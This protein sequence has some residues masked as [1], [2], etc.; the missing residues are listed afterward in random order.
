MG[1]PSLPRAKLLLFRMTGTTPSEG[2]ALRSSDIQAPLRLLGL[3]HHGS[4]N[5]WS[6]GQEC[7]P[8]YHSTPREVVV[9]EDSNETVA[10]SLLPDL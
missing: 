2:S 9:Q 6:D 8:H 10:G 4:V 3:P 5:D 1:L 7:A